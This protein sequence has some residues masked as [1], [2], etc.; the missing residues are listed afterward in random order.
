MN[1]PIILVTGGN[2]L[3]GNGIKSIYNQYPFY[4]FIFIGSKQCNLTSF[5]QTYDYFNNVKPDFVIHLASNVG[6]LFKNMEQKVKMFEDNML[7]NFNIV[8]C[9]HLFRVKKLVA[10]LST[11][12][13]PDKINYPID[14]TTLNNGPPH[15]SNEGYAYSKRILDLHCRLYREQFGS[16]FVCVIPVNVFGEHD[17]Y[18]LH[19]AHVIPA[20]IH[21]CYIAKKN[22]TNFIISGTG[23]PMRQFVH[24]V[25]LAQLIM[26]VLEKYNESDPIILSPDESDEIFIGN[27]AKII[28]DKFELDPDK[29]IFD[30]SKSDGQFK[31]TASNEKL[32]KYFPDF[33]F[34]NIHDGIHKSI[35]WFIKNYD[36]V[37]K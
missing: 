9:C 34:T 27:V 31:K 32:K 6:G 22:N 16:N 30:T 15:S 35:E 8:R 19:D 36:V 2:G 12:V 25:D 13:F 26:L 17:N 7:I 37:R 4:N 21:K 10:C 23:T 33:K 28:A 5:E 11:C 3:V 29:T 24:S 1:K 14:E 18:N 20:L